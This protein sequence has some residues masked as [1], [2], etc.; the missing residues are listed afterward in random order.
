MPTAGAILALLAL[1]ISTFF[2]TRRVLAP[3]EA[4]KPLTSEPPPIVRNAPF[5]TSP[6]ALE[7]DEL[8][9]E[10]PSS[11]SSFTLHHHENSSMQVREGT[12]IASGDPKLPYFWR[13]E[14][15]LY[16]SEFN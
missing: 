12:S 7:A 4:S 13:F 2:V 9:Y 14:N 3:N 5:L 15:A 6:E 11:Q 8:I 16:H 10:D 1:G